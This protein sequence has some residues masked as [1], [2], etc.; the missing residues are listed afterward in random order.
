MIQ[1]NVTVQTGS[2]SRNTKP[3]LVSASEDDDG[4]KLVACNL[5][6]NSQLY[7]AT[8]HTKNEEE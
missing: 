6:A 4:L 5:N 2:Y 8:S 7:L 3:L 1:F